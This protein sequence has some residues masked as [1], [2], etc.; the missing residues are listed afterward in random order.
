[1]KDSD[2]MGMSPTLIIVALACLLSLQ[3]LATDLY[4]PALPQINHALHA[5]Q[6]QTQWTLSSL[7]MALG[8]GQLLWGGWSDRI[9][10]K[11]TLLM[12]LCLLLASTCVTVLSNSLWLMIAGRIGQGLGLAATTVC[13][14]AMVRD[15]YPPQEGARMLSKGMTGLG[16]IALFGP[17]MG[18][19]AAEHWGWRGTLAL[20]GVM[21]LIW[22][23]VTASHVQETLPAARRSA[24]MA[25]HERLAQWRSMSGHTTFRVYTALTSATYGGLYIFLAATAFVFIEQLGLSR[26]IFGVWMSTLSLSYIVGTLICQQRLKRRS[27]P[28]TVRMGSALSV[29]SGL[30]CVGMSALAFAMPDWQAPVWL[31]MPGFCIYAMAHGIHQPCS[32]MGITAAFPQSAGA[33]SALAGCIMSA[34]AFGIGAVLSAWMD[35]PAW[36][37]TLHPLTLGMGGMS[38]VTAW[39]GIYW[40]QRHG[41]C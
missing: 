3:A 41:H 4:L 16:M 8:L 34:T 18:G 15:L 17:I 10:R 39:V 26:P 13:A 12:G 40:V 28:S 21:P 23:F 38:F 25:W 37:H 9:G 27:L 1:M 7:V 19:L 6:S 20:I 36:A 35:A 5:K 29:V 2:A 30:W 24:S 11:P 31:L 22:L 14:R 32:Q 33:A